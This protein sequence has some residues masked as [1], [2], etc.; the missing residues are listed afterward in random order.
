M[1]IAQERHV[2]AQLLEIHSALD[3]ALGDFDIE[4]ISLPELRDAAPVQWA[5]TKL[6][7]LIVELFP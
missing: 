4:H 7:L 3:D 6:A 1:I 5:A 2:R